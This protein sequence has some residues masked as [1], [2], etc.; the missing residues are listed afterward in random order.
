MHSRQRSSFIF[1]ERDLSPYLLVQNITR[2]V[3]PKRKIQLNQASLTGYAKPYG[4]EP[5]KIK[6]K[7]ALME[8]T[9]HGVADTRRALAETLYT[10]EPKKLFLLDDV[11]TY[12]YALYVGG[13]TPT[14]IV[15]YPSLILEFLAPDPIAYGMH[16]KKRI[17]AQE[18]VFYTG[19]TYQ[20]RPIIRCTPNQTGYIRFKNKATGEHIGVHANFNGASE[21]IIDCALERVTINGSDAQIDLDSDFFALNSGDI[22]QKDS[23]INSYELEWDERYI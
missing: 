1:N 5:M 14:E 15:K 23:D 7:C 10:D 8:E 2:E 18:H 11:S 12:V 9:L 6:V 3:V 16:C 22:L 4:F 20:T 21:L 19:G 17:T 13:C